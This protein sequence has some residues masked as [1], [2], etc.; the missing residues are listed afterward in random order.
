[1]RRPEST[2]TRQKRAVPGWDRMPKPARRRRRKDE[3][4]CARQ[5]ITRSAGLSRND[6]R[7]SP[8]TST[9][10]CD[11]RTSRVTGPLRRSIVESTSMTN[12]AP[13]APRAGSGGTGPTAAA[14]ERIRRAIATKRLLKFSLYG[15]VRIAEPHDYGIR[16]GAPQLLAYQVRGGTRSGKLPA[17]RW[18]AL[19]RASDFEVLDETFPGSRNAETQ[20][21]ADWDRL[22][23]RVD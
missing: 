16:G 5:R 12:R 13:I 15:L 19:D 1:M 17:W 11:E 8:S 10:A 6:E 9:R 22:F 7:R 14:D 4:A 21:H 2:S 18:V 3:H 23:A 20:A